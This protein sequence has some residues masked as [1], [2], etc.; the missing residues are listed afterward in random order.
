MRA[1]YKLPAL[2]ICKISTYLK[3]PH[4]LPSNRVN[5]RIESKMWGVHAGAMKLA[6][7]KKFNTCPNT[8]YDPGRAKTSLYPIY[9]SN[10]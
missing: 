6:Q 4:L 9:F 7:K 1:L 2:P 8:E 5:A 3:S 10:G